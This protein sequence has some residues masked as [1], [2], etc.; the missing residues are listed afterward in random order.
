M[1]AGGDGSAGGADGA[2]RGATA[3]CPAARRAW[4]ELAGLDALDGELD[5]RGRA[6]AARGD[7][8]AGRRATRGAS[9]RRR[10]TSATTISRRSRR[11]IG[12]ASRVVNLVDIKGL[13]H[14]RYDVIADA[15]GVR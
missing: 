14:T 12:S 8:R 1:R 11:G 10:S 13:E 15:I 3:T 6:R 7:D 2:R 5:G 9:W 4:R